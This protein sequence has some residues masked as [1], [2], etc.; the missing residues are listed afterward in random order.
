MMTVTA[1]K[2]F[3]EYDLT[4]VYADTTIDEATQSLL[5][6]WFQ[7][8]TVCDDEKF[9]IFYRRK[10][11]R[12]ERQYQQLIRLELSD[13]DPLVASYHERL[14][15]TQDNST[16]VLSSETSTSKS[17][18]DV[19]THNTQ[20]ETVVDRDTT[21]SASTQTSNSNSD[22]SV[23]ATKSNPMS[24]AYAGAT[25]GQVPALDWT[26]MSGQAQTDN[27]GSSQ[28]SS[29][30][31]GSGT[32]DSTSTTTRTGTDGRVISD[33]GSSETDQTT[34]NAGTGTVKER[35]TGRDGLTPQEAFREARK[36]IVIS[37]AFDWLKAE[38][39]DCFLGI[40]EV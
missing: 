17:G 12:V 40:V 35:I 23:S 33:S 39:N 4:Q 16:S 10:L 38:L 20:D 34:T 3:S 8:R 29:T 26:T 2:K 7:F 32:D 1:T 22:K 9:P 27:D 14:T 37:D 13:F 36:W 18:S 30:T 28:G 25:A 21:N 11:M 6:D 31:T 19:L 24:T 15:Q 5:Y